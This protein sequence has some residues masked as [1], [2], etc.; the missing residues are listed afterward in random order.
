MMTPYHWGFAAAVMPKK[1]F[2]SRVI[3]KL[4]G[5]NTCLRSLCLPHCK[6]E[7]QIRKILS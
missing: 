7:Y 4:S 2:E 3:L 5:L 6:M 1:H